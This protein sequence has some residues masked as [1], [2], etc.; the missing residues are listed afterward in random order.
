M[1]VFRRGRL[2]GYDEGPGNGG[3]EEVILL[4]DGGHGDLCRP[5]PALHHVRAG[6][7]PSCSAL[8]PFYVVKQQV[9]DEHSGF[10]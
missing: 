7:F 8:P 4:Q 3:D 5:V 10:F 9:A 1:Q 6:L 2:T